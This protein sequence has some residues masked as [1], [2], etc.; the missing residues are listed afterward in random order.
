MSVQPSHRSH[1][2]ALGAVGSTPGLEM[3]A[4]DALEQ[5]HAASSSG[6]LQ[7]MP[8]ARRLSTS[9]PMPLVADY[10]CD[11]EMLPEERRHSRMLFSP[12]LRGVNLGGWMVL[13]PWITPSLFY[14]F[15]GKPGPSVAMDM[16]SFC[17]V[18]GPEEANRQLREHWRLW[19]TEADLLRLVHQGINTLRVPVGDWMFESYGPYIGCTDGSV[20]ELVRVLRIC[21]RV[22]LK[23]LIDLHGARGPATLL[24]CGTHERRPAC[25]EADAARYL[26]PLCLR[27]HVKEHA[28]ERVARVTGRIA[29]SDMNGACGVDGVDDGLDPRPCSKPQ[30]FL[31]RSNPNMNRCAWLAERFRQLRPCQ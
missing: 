31:M 12:K 3:G 6:W 29:R 11:G 22:G 26:L 24:Q 1:A 17:R 21:N 30:A 25:S 23:V 15:E 19:V 8:S 27:A 10:V 4:I 16:H 5:A 20:L 2:C 14:Q 13:Q 9:M 18:L 28:R 7:Y